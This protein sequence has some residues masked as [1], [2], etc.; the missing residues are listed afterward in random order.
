M[1]LRLSILSFALVGFCSGC[2]SLTRYYYVDSPT[3]EETRIVHACMDELTTLGFK[4]VPC[5]STKLQGRKMGC[6]S[7]QRDDHG[8]SMTLATDLSSGRLLVLLHPVPAYSQEPKELRKA[9]EQFESCAYEQ[10]STNRLVLIEKWRQ[11]RI[12][13]LI[14]LAP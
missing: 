10:I 1:R 6:I 9:R 14:P 13:D 3:P 12:W 7:R 11:N 4:R 8:A 5:S 2:G